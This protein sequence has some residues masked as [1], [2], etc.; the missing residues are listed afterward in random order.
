M[1][2]LFFQR[3]QK[4]KRTVFCLFLILLTSSCISNKRINYL[5]NLSGNEAIGLNE[6][7]PYAQVDY[8]YVLQPFDIVDIDFASS[9]EELIKAFEFRGSNNRTGSGGVGGGGVD[10]FYHTGYA[11][12]KNGSV[13]MP[14]IGLV[15]IA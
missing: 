8:E 1:H 11:I 3:S 14:V 7:I 9:N 10:I 6:F 5:Q 2:D 12:D 15:E 13:R 4:I